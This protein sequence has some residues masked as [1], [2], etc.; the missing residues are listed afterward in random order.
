M[1]RYESFF[2]TSVLN[3]N[4]KG[5]FPI[6]PIFTAVFLSIERCKAFL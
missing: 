6:Y 4:R 5:R 3:P 1:A 2:E